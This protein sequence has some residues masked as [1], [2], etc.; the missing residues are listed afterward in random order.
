[1]MKLLEINIK[2]VSDY[3]S[4][5]ALILCIVMA[6]ISY[7]YPNNFREKPSKLMLFGLVSFGLLKMPYALFNLN[8]TS[9]SRVLMP[10]IY[11]IIS[12]LFIT[13][14]SSQKGREKE[15]K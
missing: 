5:I 7:K 13:L 6:L 8:E 9:D 10:L 4:W 3:L 12:S 14:V 1:M 15:E 11:I 2:F